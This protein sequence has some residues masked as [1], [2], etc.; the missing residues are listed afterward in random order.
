MLYNTAF[1]GLWSALVIS[2]YLFLLVHWV[3]LQSWTRSG[4]RVQLGSV[5]GDFWNVLDSMCYRLD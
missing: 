3:A 2:S 5:L 4:V 1:L